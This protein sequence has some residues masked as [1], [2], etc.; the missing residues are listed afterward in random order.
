MD[1]TH[2]NRLTTESAPTTRQ[3][4]DAIAMAE[5][6]VDV[7]IAVL[8]AVFTY[9]VYRWTAGPS[10]LHQSGQPHFV[11]LA[12]AILHG[13]LWIDPTRAARL[14]DVTPFAGRYYVS[15]PPMP[16]ILMLPFVA[17]FGPG[18]DDRLFSIALGAIDVALA[19]LLVRRLSFPG[20]AGP[21]ISVDRLAAGG[22]AL[23]LGLGTV[24]FYA[25]LAGTVWF[26][27]HVVSV[28][29]ALL[30][31]MECAGSGRP[32][33]AGTALAA[34]FLARTPT[35]FAL[36][37]WVV[38]AGRRSDGLARIVPRAIRLAVPLAIAVALLLGQNVARFGSPFDFGYLSMHIANT[39]QPGLLQYGQ[40]SAHFLL[41]NFAA[42]FVTAP[43]VASLDL[44]VWWQVIGGHTGLLRDLTTTGPNSGVP[45]PVTFDPW[46]TG[47]WAV[48]PA[49]A[50]SLRL[51]R[52][53]DLAL[54]GAAWLSALVVAMPDLLYYNTGWVQYGYRFSLDFVPFLLILTAMGLR[55]PLH[56][57]WR[58]LFV[59]LLVIS[60]GSNFLGARWFLHLP[61]Y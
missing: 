26:I 50:F 19:Y 9:V 23:L 21:G 58:A 56:P 57:L 55:R 42:L 47:L 51:P 35:I 11:L 14:G 6:L 48:S 22:I 12:D 53:Q 31:L 4:D 30:Y 25:A 3:P 39:L 1:V 27:A 44:P 24:Q 29:F 59:V 15:F 2:E 37:F 10:A 60:I 54:A 40:F 33:V 20:F 16:A 5:K 7:S 36:V 52:R 38:L 46:G 45:F 13:H 17:A 28:T 49:L 43:I 61:P 32:I 8:L 41:R 18:F 34:A